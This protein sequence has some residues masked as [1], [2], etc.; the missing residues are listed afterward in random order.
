MLFNTFI[1]LIFLIILIPINYYLRIKYRNIFLIIISYLFYGYWDYRFCVLLLITT[2]IVFL[3]GKYIYESNSVKKRKYILYLTLISNLGILCYFKYFNFFID[4][5]NNITQIFGLQLDFLHLNII[6]PVGIS[7]YTFQSLTYTID[8]Y[9]NK[10]EPTKSFINFMLFV[11]FFPQ[12]LAGPIERA[13]NILPQIEKLSKP[14]KVQFQQGLVLIT[15]GM[16]KKILIGDTTGRI[17]DQIFSQPSYF[18]SPILLLG[19][20]LF[21]VQVY[22]DFSGYSNIARGIAKWMGIEL[23]KNFNQPYLAINITEFWKRWHI[24][25]TTWFRDYIFLPISFYISWKIKKR[26]VFFLK[27]DKFIYIIASIITWLLTGL[28]HGASWNFVVWGG[29]H[30][31][32]LAVHK[33][34]FKRKKDQE[35]YKFKSAQDYFSFITKIFFTNL[36]VILT[37]IFFRANSFNDAFV[38]I[39]KLIY[40]DSFELLTRTI[41]I[42]FGFYFV[43]ILIDI[44]EYYFKE[45]E[46]LLKLK[47]H[48]RNSIIF[49][50]WL[51]IILFMFQATPMPFVYFQF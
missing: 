43:I 27:T 48:Y 6:L 39:K 24:S 26:K 20:L 23:M 33:L 47:P 49:A 17:V 11:S 35:K 44:C 42:S 12:L 10:L 51:I 21:S 2:V 50:I 40:W 45:H 4:S 31:L 25:L 34:F 18:T 5:F 37:W 15:T 46:F 28:W 19:L 30:G 7:F 8:I 36:L 14:T 38:I 22:A 1:F 3:S 16:L 41:T 13:K 32:I 29:I 9:R